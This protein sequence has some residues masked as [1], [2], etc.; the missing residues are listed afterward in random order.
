MSGVLRRAYTSFSRMSGTTSTTFWL[1]SN[2]QAPTLC[3]PYPV[4]IVPQNLLNVLKL[5]WPVILAKRVKLIK[6][7]THHVGSRQAHT[8]THTHKH[9]T[10]HAYYVQNNKQ[11]KI[12]PL[13]G[14]RGNAPPNPP[15][16]FG[17]WYLTATVPHIERH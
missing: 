16:F 14:F 6:S 10:L 1:E 7:H 2:L 11:T 3:C 15:P 5:F 8:H 12:I 9:S 4:T 13:L 17:I